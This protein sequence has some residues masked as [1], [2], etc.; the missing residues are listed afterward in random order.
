MALGLFLVLLPGN[1]VA[2]IPSLT[3][4]QCGLTVRLGDG[5]Y[6]NCGTLGSH[7]RL[8]LCVRQALMSPAAGE[9]QQLP[10]TCGLGGRLREAA[11]NLSFSNTEEGFR[12]EKGSEPGHLFGWGLQQVDPALLEHLCHF[13]RVDGSDSMSEHLKEGVGLQG[14]TDHLMMLRIISKQL[15]SS[16]QATQECFRFLRTGNPLSERIAHPLLHT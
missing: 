14:H 5:G 1:K 13:I 11:S 7:V 16:H 4:L 2:R 6:R 3:C 12:L 10:G 9:L 15:I 8:D